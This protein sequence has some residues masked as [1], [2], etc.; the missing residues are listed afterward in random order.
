MKLSQLAQALS[1]TIQE[2]SRQCGRLEE[3]G[4][5]EKRPDSKFG[6]T[7]LGKTTLVLLPSFRFLQDEKEYFL[8]H[9]ALSLPPE[10]VERLGELTDS[11]RIDHINDALNFQQKV[12]KESQSFVW[13]MS[14]QP[15]G[16]SLR[17]DHSQFSE[18]T[19]MRV[20]LP[21]DVDTEIFHGAKNL[22]GSRLQVGLLEEV[23][24]VIAMNEKS[25]AFSL[26]TLDGSST[27]AADF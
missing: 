21:A 3:A 19:A 27:I 10:F 20:I 16:H 22:M 17:P 8:A 18:N 24:L 13:F 7:G 25:A 2:A 1:S 11:K 12:V 6:L 23:K 5:I 26:P 4:L 9:D 15:V 14:D